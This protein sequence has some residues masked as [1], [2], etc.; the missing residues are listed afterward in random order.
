MA[1]DRPFRVYFISSQNGVFFNRISS[2]IFFIQNSIIVTKHERNEK[3][4][5][6]RTYS[7]TNLLKMFHQQVYGAHRSKP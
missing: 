3:S 1:T 5:V 4:P 2:I 6:C 7:V